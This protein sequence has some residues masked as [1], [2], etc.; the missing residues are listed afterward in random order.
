MGAPLSGEL[1]VVFCCVCC[2]LLFSFCCCVFIFRVY[3]ATFDAIAS[4]CLQVLARF[5]LIVL[6][7]HC[8]G[9]LVRKVPQDSVWPHHISF[10]VAECTLF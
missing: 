2:F 9:A 3:F 8:P 6:V 7:S 1:D 10:F 4:T 5:S